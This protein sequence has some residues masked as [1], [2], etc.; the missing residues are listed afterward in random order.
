MKRLFTYTTIITSTLAFIGCNKQLNQ[1]PISSLPTSAFWQTSQDASTGT[2]S[3]YAGMQ[4]VFSSAFIE[5]GDARSDNFT[6]GGTGENQID[7]ALNGLN[8][9]DASADWGNI[10]NTILRANLAIKYIPNII[11]LTQVQTNNYLS[12]AYGARAFMYFWAV[13]VWGD[14]PVRLAPYESIDSTPYLARS[15]ADSV[16]TNV[17]IPDLTKALSLVDNTS[18][19]TFIITK[20]SILAMLSEVYMW[21]KDYPNVLATTAQLMAMNRYSLVPAYGYKDVFVGATTAENIWTLNWNWK[22]DGRND[23]GTKIGSNGNT[24]N[25]VI[26]KGLLSELELNKNDIRRNIDYDTAVA[27]ANLPLTVI[28]KYYPMD[29]STGK[30][31]TPPRVQNEAKLPFYRWPDI[32]LMRAEALNLGKNDKDSAIILVNLVRARAGATPLLSA[33]YPAT[34]DIENA[35]LNERQLELFAEGKRWF[36][37]VRT[38]TL[39]NNNLITLMDPLIRARQATLKITPTGFLDVRK[40]LWPVS[41]QALISD[42]LLIQNPPYSE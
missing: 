40:I 35:V 32:L 34:L 17:V 9:T 27:S 5:W 10:Y 2:A 20:G 21:K 28:W 4:N 41:R 29:V 23:I 31:A 16:L 1:Q 8:S 22:T 11:G 26:D 6:Y 15:N 7:V 30:P 42:P 33:N 19:S 36:D 13:R 14:V 39:L 38:N 24:S 37:L 25:Y 3:I 18:Y 12:Q